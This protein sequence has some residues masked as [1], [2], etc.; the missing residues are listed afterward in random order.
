MGSCCPP[1]LILHFKMGS[2]FCI[3]LVHDCIHPF[4]FV[5]LLLFYLSQG[6]LGTCYPPFPIV[7]SKMSSINCISFVHDCIR[8]FSFVRLLLFYLSLG[9]GV[10]GTCYPPFSDFGFE[11]AIHFCCTTTPDRSHSDTVGRVANKVRVE[12]G[13]QPL[14]PRSEIS[15]F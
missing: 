4:S 10:L 9:E 15:F 6:R 12:G 1:F 7:N 8:A 3:S 13:F 11:S 5:H 2:I 14:L